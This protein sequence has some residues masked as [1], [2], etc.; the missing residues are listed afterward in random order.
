MQ[1]NNPR[2]GCA[3]RAGGGTTGRGCWSVWR[4]SMLIA[5]ASLCQAV[6]M[7]SA[8]HSITHSLIHSLMQLPTPSPYAAAC[9]AVPPFFFVKNTNTAPFWRLFSVTC[10]DG[11]PSWKMTTLNNFQS[12]HRLIDLYF[13]FERRKSVFGFFI[14]MGWMVMYFWLVWI[15]SVSDRITAAR[16]LLQKH[17][18]FTR[19]AD[20]LWNRVC[21]RDEP[22][23]E[24]RGESNYP[25]W[26]L[27]D[28]MSPCDSFCYS[29]RRDEVQSRAKMIKRVS[30]LP[31]S[32]EGEVRWHPGGF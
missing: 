18:N 16:S 9:L 29:D 3:P 25:L 20:S 17:S 4:R 7:L 21:G 23:P 2:P 22:R 11:S 12:Q 19:A 1:V 5:V 28:D 14:D 31:V 32:L 15:G 10:K 13:F 30:A 8:L 6:S 26:S 24:S 27:G